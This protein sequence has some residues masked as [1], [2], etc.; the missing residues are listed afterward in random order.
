M[1]LGTAFDE[2]Q[3][4]FAGRVP[5][6]DHEHGPTVPRVPLRYSLEWRRSPR[7]RSI[8][9]QVGR[10]GTR[11]RPVATTTLSD[12]QV[13][14]ARRRLPRPVHPLH[15]LHRLAEVRPEVEVLPV[16]LQVLDDLVPSR[17]PRP[18]PGH[19]QA[20]AVREKPFG[21]CRCRR[22]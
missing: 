20:R 12:R 15:P 1:D 5:E 14:S 22:S 10:T 11:V 2:V 7:Y 4:L 18:T 19:G 6:P 17:I 21:V 13:P 3:R 8:P 9:G 16:E